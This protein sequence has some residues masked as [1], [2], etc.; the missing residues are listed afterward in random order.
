MGAHRNKLWTKKP[1]G[2]DVPP[3][4]NHN[5]YSANF[6]ENKEEGKDAPTVPFIE[7]TLAT[8][9]GK[10]EGEEVSKTKKSV[11]KRRYPLQ[12]SAGIEN[13]LFP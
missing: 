2:K 6:S 5:A 9:K 10:L 11:K 13:Q 3:R 1:R 7:E 12:F 8:T 4:P